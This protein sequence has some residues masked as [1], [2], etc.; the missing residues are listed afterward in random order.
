[1]SDSLEF[2]I[3]E[4]R[5]KT[6]IELR[7][8]Q[9]RRRE[10]RER[11]LE[12]LCK[13]HVGGDAVSLSSLCELLKI[14]WPTIQTYLRR[15]GYRLRKLKDENKESWVLIDHKTEKKGKVKD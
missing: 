12:R 10:V 11:F 13:A 7:P 2:D 4:V 14:G 1:M 6:R 3:S 9:M 5:T 8:L 15:N